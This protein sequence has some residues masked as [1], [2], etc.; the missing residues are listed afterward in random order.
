ME[1]EQGAGAGG[2]TAH[3]AAQASWRRT[4]HTRAVKQ[5]E[6][7]HTRGDFVRGL[8]ET[9]SPGG[10]GSQALGGP[11]PWDAVVGFRGT[12]FLLSFV[13]WEPGPLE[14]LEVA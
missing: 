14:H 4:G 9:R 1:A 5:R 8:V 3:F 6:G 11:Y 10:R 2:R 7:T 13:T 12:L